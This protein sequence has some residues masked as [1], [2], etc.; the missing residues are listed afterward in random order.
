MDV[1]EIGYDPTHNSQRGT[2]AK[3]SERASDGECCDVICERDEDLEGGEA[4]ETDEEG[5]IVAKYLRDVPE[6]NRPDDEALKVFYLAIPCHN[7]S[8]Q[9]SNL[10]TRNLILPTLP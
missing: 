5:D 7:T 6:E 8:N 1:P 9:S 3:A 10:R 4:S 2:G